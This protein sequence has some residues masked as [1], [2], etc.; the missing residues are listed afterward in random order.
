MPTHWLM[1][2]TLTCALLTPGTSWADLPALIPRDILF[3]NPERLNPQIS[4]DGKYLA[5]L[6]PD[7]NNVVQVWL[8]TVGQQDDKEP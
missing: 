4:P 8:R 6:A 3:G 2:T 1:A 7:T 5:Y